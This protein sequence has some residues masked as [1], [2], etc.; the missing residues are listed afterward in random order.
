[1]CAKKI[2]QL[3]NNH[4]L[5]CFGLCDKGLLWIVKKTDICCELIMA[6]GDW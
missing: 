6:Y 2:K 1:V 3:I 4:L 5:I